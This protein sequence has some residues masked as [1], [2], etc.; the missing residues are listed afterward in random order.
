MPLEKHLLR[1]L[2]TALVPVAALAVLALPESAP[3][4]VPQF[5]LKWGSFGTGDGFFRLPRRVAVGPDGSVYVA[6]RN[7]ARIQKFTG[8]GTFV[9]TWGT[10]GSGDGQFDFP[11]GV[12][13][14]DSGFVYVAERNNNRIQKFTGDGTFVL[15][16]GTAGVG[17]GEFSFPVGVAVGPS[18]DVYVADS[19]NHRIQRFTSSGVFLREWGRSGTLDGEFDTPVTLAVDRSGNVYVGD[20]FN[21]RIQ[22][23]TR[24]GTFLAKW[25]SQGTGDGQFGAP[26]GIGVGPGGNIYVVDQ[27]NNRVQ[28]FTSGG[29]FLLKFGMQGSGDGQFI[30]PE[31]CD[32]DAGGNIFVT[33]PSNHR[34]QKFG[35]AIVPVT[36]AYFAV[37]RAG[38]AAVLEWRVG[39]LA[40]GQVAFHVYRSERGRHGGGPG[41]T[42]T[43]LTGTPL[44]GTG[45]YTDGRA[46]RDGADYWLREADSDGYWHGPVS[47]AP[48]PALPLGLEPNYPNPFNPSTVIR[49]TVR[50]AA[51]VVLAIYDA[52]GR[53]VRTLVDAPQAAGAY[54]VRWNG[55]GD[56]G[57]ALPSGV[58]FSRLW[59]GSSTVTHKM[60]LLK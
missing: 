53:R 44:T 24:D 51:R 13:A 10:P 40:A 57:A 19:F 47:L 31:D 55:R 6:D 42:R 25:G 18:G 15:K 16:W 58:Y 23:F 33:D 21:F 35:V 8:E 56:N 11:F 48:V 59:S 3:A 32:V 4:Q 9:T 46:P 1:T 12:A 30:R 20:S 38:E 17:P 36:L 34:I 14:D 37:R 41:G 60:V 7:N 43:R 49:Y 29:V 39:E 5:I 50:E 45:R 54:E 27:L 52:G 22:K 26:R 2:R 28:K